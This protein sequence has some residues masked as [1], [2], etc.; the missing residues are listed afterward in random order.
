M[1]KYKS[2][3]FLKPNDK[4]AIVS[5]ASAVQEEPIHKAKA[6]IAEQ[7]YEVLL[8]KSILNRHHNFGGTDEERIQDLQNA[9]DDPEVKAIFSSRGGYGMTRI[10]DKLDFSKFQ[11]NPKWIIGFSDITG[12][13]LKIQTLGYQSIHGPMPSTFKFDKGSLNRLFRL[14]NG[15]GIEL[16]VKSKDQNRIG[17]AIAP[18][19]GGNLCLLAHSLGSMADISYDGSILFVEDIGEY[20]YSIDRMFVQLKRAGKLNKVKGVIVGDFSD[21][22]EQSTPFGKSI[23][24]IVLE[25]VGE[26]DI[27][28]AFGFPMGHDKVNIPF[29]LGEEVTLEVNES[30]SSLNNYVTS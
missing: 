16:I 10:L 6:I 22:K 20:M 23:E 26:L 19:V 30:K 28:I 8:G 2:P 13:H 18:I 4:I 17:K 3:P 29:R 11:K 7:G 21:V 1:S 15:E 5:M 27:P 9:L 12:L 14:L 25:H 24:E